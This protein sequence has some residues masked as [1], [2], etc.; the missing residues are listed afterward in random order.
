[1]PRAAKLL[2]LA[3]LSY[4]LAVHAAQDQDFD[5]ALAQYD[6]GRYEQAFATFAKLADDGHCEAARIAREMMRF[7]AELYAREF[8]LPQ[9]RA[10]RWPQ[11][12]ACLATGTSPSREQPSAKRIHAAIDAPLHRYGDL[13]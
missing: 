7:G 13:P 5:D 1:M 8:V 10:E 3:A 6:A 4:A 2:A 12:P 9:D 11:R